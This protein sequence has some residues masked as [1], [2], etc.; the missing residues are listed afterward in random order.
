MSMSMNALNPTPSSTLAAPSNA[1]TTTATPSSNSVTSSAAITGSG[2][3]GNMPEGNPGAAF[4]GTPPTGSN[5]GSFTV[6]ATPPPVARVGGWLRALEGPALGR[7]ISPGAIPTVRSPTRLIPMRPEGASVLPGRS[8]TAD[9]L[10]RIFTP[11]SRMRAAEGLPQLSST[12]SQDRLSSVVNPALTAE[13]LAQFERLQP[14]QQDVARGLLSAALSELSLPPWQGGLEAARNFDEV[15]GI[16]LERSSQ[17][18]DP[19]S[20]AAGAAPLPS[21][22]TGSSRLPNP[23]NTSSLPNPAT[24]PALPEG[25]IATFQGTTRHGTLTTEVYRSATM[26]ESKIRANIDLL[27]QKNPLLYAGLPTEE[28]VRTARNSDFFLVTTQ[29]GTSNLFGHRAPSSTTAERAI[30]AISER[31]LSA[32]QYGLSRAGR[33]AELTFVASNSDLRGGGGQVVRQAEDW[34]RSRGLDGVTFYNTD[35]TGG[36]SR[37]F[38]QHMGYTLTRETRV[39]VRSLDARV[40]QQLIDAGQFTRAQIDRGDAELPRYYFEKRFD[41]TAPP[42]GA[43]P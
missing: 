40:Q 43:R 10:L 28:L 7:P 13:R 35:T 12:L 42:D 36:A 20:P 30:T 34:A 41:N 21:P 38:Y 4:V 2:L 32:G 17:W 37:G 3:I 18:Q 26:P 22:A 39:D 33:Y 6:A 23:L 5:D 29:H 31:D 14:A 1:A 24:Q 8:G 19:R 15:V 16:I 11:G 25:A 9:P 27:Q